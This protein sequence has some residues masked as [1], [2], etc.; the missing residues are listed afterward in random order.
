MVNGWDQKVHRFSSN[1]CWSNIGCLVL[2]PTLGI[3]GSRV[4]EKGESQN[5][6]VNKRKKI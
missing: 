6:S 3:G 4:W 5:M 2:D 1:E